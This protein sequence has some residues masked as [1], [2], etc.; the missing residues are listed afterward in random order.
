MSGI[1]ENFLKIKKKLQCLNEKAENWKIKIF[2]FQI[3]F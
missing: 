1:Q 2:Q 3:F